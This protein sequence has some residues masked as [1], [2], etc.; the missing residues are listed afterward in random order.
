M[1]M[2]GGFI[3]DIE[4]ERKPDFKIIVNLNNYNDEDVEED[5][6]KSLSLLLKNNNG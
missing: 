3:T 5:L 1:I 6:K 2:I 4:N